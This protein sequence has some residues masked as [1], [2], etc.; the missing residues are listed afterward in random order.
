MDKQIYNRH[1]LKDDV[2]SQC[3]NIETDTPDFSTVINNRPGNSLF[4][5][6]GD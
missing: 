4:Q 5:T 6:T 3:I 1:R 2:L